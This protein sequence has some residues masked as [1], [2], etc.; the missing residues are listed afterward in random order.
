MATFPLIRFDSLPLSTSDGSNASLVA[1]IGNTTTVR[2]RWVDLTAKFAILTDGE[3]DGD[4]ESDFSIKEDGV[5]SRHN[6]VWGKSPRYKYENW[7]DLTKD[8]RFLRVDSTMNLTEDEIGNTRKSLNI[9][10]ADHTTPGFVLS[11]PKESAFD[12]EVTDGR[13][14]NSIYVNPDGSISLPAATHKVF[15]MV[16]LDNEFIATDPWPDQTTA[17][18]GAYVHYAVGHAIAKLWRTPAT[19]TSIGMVMGGT[20]PNSVNVDDDTGAMTVP[21]A[22]TPGVDKPGLTYLAH[23]TYQAWYANKDLESSWAAPA[24]LV[25]EMVEHKMLFHQIPAKYNERLGA[26]MP[27][28]NILCGED[29]DIYVQSATTSKDGVV[30]LAPHQFDNSTIREI[31]Y[32]YGDKVPDIKSV[33]SFIQ[34]FGFVTSGSLADGIP[35]ASTAAIGGIKASSTIYINDDGSAYVPNATHNM[36]G[37]CKVFG[38]D[39]SEPPMAANYHQMIDLVGPASEDSPGTV[40]VRGYTYQGTG[41][42]PSVVS[43]DEFDSTILQAASEG[44]AGLVKVKNTPH[45]ADQEY[46][47]VPSYDEFQSSL[48]PATS[49]TPGRVRVNGV[50]DDSEYPLVPTVDDLTDLTLTNC[51][52]SDCEVFYISGQSNSVSFIQG[53][54]N[55][56]SSLLY[57]KMGTGSSIVFK[58]NS[59]SVS[60]PAYNKMVYSTSTPDYTLEFDLTIETTKNNTINFS[61]WVIVGIDFDIY[62]LTNEYYTYCFKVHYDT[63]GQRWVLRYLYSYSAI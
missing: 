58:A 63:A 6:S 31:V 20:E 38:A 2:I 15:G 54:Q 53:T 36:P 48:G 41:N 42:Y 50:V 61:G 47:A 56:S 23:G 40:K 14:E 7:G 13:L 32:Y 3:I 34:K 26:V 22:I 10:I 30:V 8:T 51:P 19:N 62:P 28:I 1:V 37:V 44:I 52:G 59:N 33:H 45:V 4:T 60:S 9:Q 25:E 49:V 57:Y 55:V 27:T 16:K 11:K 39:G 17:V 21:L 46:V 35:V 5:F 24:S 43:A 12:T 18:T 29:G